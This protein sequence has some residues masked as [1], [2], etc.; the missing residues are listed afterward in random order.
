MQKAQETRVVFLGESGSDKRC[1]IHRFVA[2][3]E[4]RKKGFKQQYEASDV[5]ITECQVS[6]ESH[7]FTIHFWDFGEDFGDQHL[8]NVMYSCFLTE[9]ICF[10]ITIQSRNTEIDNNIQYWMWNVRK[11]AKDAPVLLLVDCRESGKNSF[12]NES[13]IRNDFP[14]IKDI[15]YCPAHETETDDSVF[16]EKIMEPIKKLVFE[17]KGASKEVPK[18]WINVRNAI[19]TRHRNSSYLLQGQFCSLCEENGITNEQDMEMLHFFNSLGICFSFH[20]GETIGDPVEYKLLKP[21]W[22]IKAMRTVIKEGVKY[23]IDGCISR[24]AV[25][26]IYKNSSLENI[27]DDHQSLTWS[28]MLCIACKHG[29]C[30]ELDDH[31]LFFP[32]LCDTNTPAAAQNKPEDYCKRSGCL[33]RYSILPDEVLDRLMVECWKAQMHVLRRWREGMILEVWRRHRIIVC[34]GKNGQAE[35]LRIEVWSN[36]DY[37]AKEDFWFLRNV[38]DEI[39]EEQNLNPRFIITD[40]KPKPSEATIGV[41]GDAHSAWRYSD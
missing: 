22:L 4:K 21:D 11:F 15:V 13:Q 8:R 29:L 38:V 34:K 40:E 32:A 1:A 24:D 26:Q 2:L 41:I 16:R 19:K 20:I 39:N 14:Q 27:Q 7:C 6:I 31:T 30:Y 18:S 25:K 5:L 35:D 17:S 10:V 33:Y 23:A 37:Q 9:G 36:Q 3:A 28:Y 12:F